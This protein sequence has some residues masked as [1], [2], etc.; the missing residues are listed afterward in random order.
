MSRK[1]IISESEKEPEEKLEWD[2]TKIVIACVVVIGLIGTGLFF[3]N[4]FLPS[5]SVHTQQSVRGIS[6]SQS[7]EN[8]ISSDLPSI[9]SIG[10]GVQQE[11]KSLQ[12]QAQTISL[13][14]VASSSP[15]VKQIIQQLQALPHLPQSVAKQTC[16]QICGKL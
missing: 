2:K 5:Q 10:Q 11:I 1:K 14:E 4:F 6:F 8:S 9:K 13:E 12:K 3:K 7:Q 16:E 15:Q